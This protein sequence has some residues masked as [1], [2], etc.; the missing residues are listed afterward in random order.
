MAG[1]VGTGRRK[2]RRV[3]C[4]NIKFTVSDADMDEYVWCVLMT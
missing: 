2:Q 4:R 1:E 3:S